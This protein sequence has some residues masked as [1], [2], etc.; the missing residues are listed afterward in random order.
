MKFLINY[1]PKSK[2]SF[3]LNSVIDEIRSIGKVGNYFTTNVRKINA[4]TAPKK[5]ATNSRPSL[6]RI[7]FIAKSTYHPTNKKK[8]KV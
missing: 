5:T 8:L 6:A 7:F 2:A 4:A 3:I 1:N